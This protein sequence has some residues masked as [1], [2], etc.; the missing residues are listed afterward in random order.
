VKK[1]T[2]QRS[3]L[4]VD[5]D[6][7]FVSVER[8]LDA[9]LRGRPVVVGGQFGGIVAAAS[10][11]ARAFGIAAGQT[12]AEARQ[13]CP[14]AVVRSGDLDAYARI[15]EEVSTVLLSVSRRVE[16]PS[17]DEAYVDLTPDAAGATLPVPAAEL[18]KDE[19]QR[20]LKLEVSLG[21]ASS[22]LAARVASRGARPRGLL[23]VLPGYEH[24][25]L[26]RQPISVLEDLPPHLET[27]LTEAG[28]VTLEQLLAADEAQVA[29]LVGAAAANRLRAAARCDDEQPIAVAAPP[30]WTSEEAHIRD[31]RTDRAALVDVTAGLASRAARRLRP[32]D[33]AA[34]M[35]TV[36]I[37]RRTQAVRRSEALS[38]AVAD[39][40][41]L[42]AVAQRLVE[43]LLDPAAGVRTIEVRLTRLRRTSPQ[44][45]LFP[46][47]RAL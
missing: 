9:S 4:H 6:P 22:R 8:S 42:Q 23:V 18:V 27:A 12:L 28:L 14:R 2:R 24:R 47:E 40:A 31:R 13:R 11:E 25:F 30:H 19:L 21:L 34:G 45:S 3:I 37:R 17:T 44:A 38:S 33:L 41:T 20:R 36:E 1:G 15:S 26:G 5:L 32:F 29:G 16:R 43:P 10:L 46:L 35:L 7:F 39:E